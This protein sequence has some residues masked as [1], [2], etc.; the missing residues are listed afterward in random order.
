MGNSNIS[1]NRYKSL[2][3][4]RNVKI[5]FE[6]FASLSLLQ[7]AG[8]V[9]PLIT[10]PYLARTLGVDKF[11]AIAFGASVVIY[12]HTVVDYGFH[13][14]AVRDISKNRD[15]IALVSKLFSS[16]LV[17][18]FVLLLLSFLVLALLVELI[19]VFTENKQIIYLS[20]LYLPGHILFPD[21]YF[22]GIEKMKYI[23]LMNVLSKLVFTILVFVVIKDSSDYIYQPVLMALGYF[24]SGVISLF[25]VFSRFRIRFVIPT[26][27]EVLDTLKGGW[28]MFIS[29]MLPN[30]YTNFSVILLRSFGGEGPTGIYSS[31][32]KFIFLTSNFTTV[33]SR[34]FFPFL[35][36]RLDKHTVFRNISGLMSILMSLFLFFGADLLV[37]IFYTQ[38][39]SQA[40]TVIRIMSPSPFFLFLM[41]TYGTNFLV[42]VNRENTFRNIVL[43]GSLIGFGLSW[44][45]VKEFT[46]IGAAVTIVVTRTILGMM[47][48]LVARTIMKKPEPSH[49]SSK[50][51]RNV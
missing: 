21:W 27:K 9:F 7:F 36:R 17:S 33:L 42:L 48:W 16:V 6:N 5:L 15:D 30:L 4:N 1:W 8:Y 26:P 38:E 19:P 18:R 2:K 11:G 10:L 13:F 43:I 32:S 47:T 39:F 14:T 40:A 24:V 46:F 45:L 49:P 51:T 20:F 22:Q 3:A 23:T 50:I 41:N 28:D 35:A 31:G 29:S 25:I 12:F 44:L 37:R 34:T